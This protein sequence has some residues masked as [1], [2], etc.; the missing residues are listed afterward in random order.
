MPGSMLLWAASRSNDAAAGREPGV[1]IAATAPQAPIAPCF[2]SV[3]V[4]VVWAD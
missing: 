1:D 2:E 4:L 3:A